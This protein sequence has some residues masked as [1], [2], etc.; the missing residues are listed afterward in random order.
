MPVPSGS[1]ET[2]YNPPNPD[3]WISDMC[4]KTLEG[5][6]KRWGLQG[7]VNIGETEDFVKGQL[8]FGGFPNATKL[9]QSS[10]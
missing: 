10:R 6:R 2:K 3:Y 9:E 1:T 8:Q 7:G 5:C 4:S